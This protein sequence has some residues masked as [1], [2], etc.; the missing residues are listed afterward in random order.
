MVKYDPYSKGMEKNV[1]STWIVPRYIYSD[2]DRFD[3]GVKYP[4]YLSFTGYHYGVSISEGDEDLQIYVN[5][6]GSAVYPEDSDVVIR[7]Q[8]T[9]NILLRKA[10]EMWNL[11]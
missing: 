3:Y 7:N 6:D 2:A 10:E 4:D 8:E 11:K 1:F 5:A 9:I